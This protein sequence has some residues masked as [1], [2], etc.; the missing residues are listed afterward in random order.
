MLRAKAAD[1]INNPKI[2]L[3]RNFFILILYTISFKNSLWSGL[4]V[5]SF[6]DGSNYDGEWSNGFM[7]GQGTFTWAD[8]KQKI[9][10][11][12]NGKLQE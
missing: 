8:G 9:G 6:P 12:K 1:V 5:L 4:G 2:M 10:I 11:W 3:I 7:N